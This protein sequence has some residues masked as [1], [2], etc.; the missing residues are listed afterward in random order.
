VTPRFEFFTARLLLLGFF[1]SQN[2]PKTQKVPNSQ[3]TSDTALG[4]L[5]RSYSL[6]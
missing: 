4:Q 1:S 5:T 2:A 6:N 3:A